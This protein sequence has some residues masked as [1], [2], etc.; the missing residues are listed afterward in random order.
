MNTLESVAIRRGEPGDAEA[1]RLLSQD[2]GLPLPF[3]TDWPA[4][5]ASPAHFVYVAEDNSIF[6]FVAAGAPLDPL[7]GSEGTG[8]II[9]LCVKPGYQRQG[10][11]TKLLVRGISVLKRRT[12]GRAHVWLPDA[13]PQVVRVFTA[14]GFEATGVTRITNLESRPWRESGFEM[15][16]DAFF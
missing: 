4:L 10:M 5:L 3:R 6:G 2:L 15:G 11:G 13:R 16:L 9:G 12:F 1:I 8:E 14:V 7:P